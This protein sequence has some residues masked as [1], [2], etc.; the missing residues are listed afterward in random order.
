M[1]YSPQTVNTK[2]QSSGTSG[3]STGK[4]QGSSS[5]STVGSSTS[6]TNS[7]GTSVSIGDISGVTATSDRSTTTTH[8]HSY[9]KGTEMSSSKSSENSH[10]AS[11]SIKDWGAYS[12]VSPTSMAPSW[13][14][15]QEYP[16]DAIECRKTNDKP[17]AKN[18]NQTQ[19]IIPGMMG[20]RLY[21]G[22]SLYPPSHLSMFGINFIMK[23]LWLVTIDDGGPE[24]IT[25]HHTVNYFSGSHL[26]EKTDGD[27][28]T[29]N[30][31]M[32]KHPSILNVKNDDPLN[33]KINLT[34]MGLDP[35]GIQTR[36]AVIGFIP[37]KFA[38]LPVPATSSKQPVPFK[39]IST[40][41]DLMVKDCTTYPKDCNEG[42]GF[43]PSETALT[44][45]LSPK[46]KQLS[47]S[48]YFKIT[49]SISDY[50][51]FIKHWKTGS[52][53]SSGV[54][55][56]FVINEDTKN[57]IKKYVDA[58]EAEGGE[59]NLL[60]LVLRNQNYASVD[61]HDYLQLGLNSIK[62]TIESIDDE[63]FPNCGYQ[64]R[65]ISIEKSGTY[66]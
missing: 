66:A 10:S 27:I 63:H 8:D 47:I 14:F 54:M 61:Y 42:D 49:D 60:T 43:I 57:P 18:A 16:W 51:L 38:T 59:N 24:D 62:I 31:Y 19:I 65:A 55:L 15:G 5:S 4:T 40:S 34:L 17:N 48:L 64:I 2:V 22:V 32:D 58:L 36:G 9:T 33:T 30:V 45:N 7:Y 44:A 29:V 26:L 12:L 39:I 52:A 11:M 46:C 28:D 23:A 6:Q 20:V 53:N 37:N 41:N 13:T 21:D 3:D 35:L 1:E 56:T 50:N 25:I